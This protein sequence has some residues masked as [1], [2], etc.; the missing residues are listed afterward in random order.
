[1]ALF[2]GTS[3]QKL[4]EKGRL[5]LPA[6]YREAFTAGLVVTRGQEGCVVI[7]TPEEFAKQ[8]SSGNDAP[9]TLKGVRDYQ[10]WLLADASD[11]VPDRQGRFGVPAL[12]R[13]AARLERD[14]AVIGAGNRL[15]VWEPEAWTQYSTA[16][17]GS[18]SDMNEV[19]VPH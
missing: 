1:M 9:T 2:M 3:L 7:Y 13:A 18:F 15:E 4:D 11:Q 5:V 8:L 6:K 10:R 14:V 16:L 19:V 17:H 12:L